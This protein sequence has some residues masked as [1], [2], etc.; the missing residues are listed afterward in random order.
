MRGVCARIAQ[1]FLL[2]TNDFL[3]NANQTDGAK[4]EKGAKGAKG[5]KGER[6]SVRRRVGAE[7]GRRGEGSARRRGGKM[8]GGLT[9]NMGRVERVYIK[10]YKVRARGRRVEVSREGT[11]E[12]FTPKTFTVP[13]RPEVKA[14]FAMPRLK[15][16]GA[17]SKTCATLHGKRKTQK[18]YKKEPRARR[19][20]SPFIPI[21]FSRV[22]TFPPNPT[23]FG[24]KV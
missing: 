5:A 15:K 21:R 6:G 7:K 10:L 1:K 20:Y 11:S 12:R 24:F 18:K 9:G 14:F 4:G 19:A 2:K 8:R 22:H 13:V 3:L 17:Y 16:G 23:Q